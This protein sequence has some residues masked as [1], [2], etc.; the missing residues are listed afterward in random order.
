[1]ICDRLKDNKPLFGLARNHT[2]NNFYK[3]CEKMKNLIK[4]FK[5]N[6]IVVLIYITT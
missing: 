6:E 3:N 2:F 4:N 5:F 1:M